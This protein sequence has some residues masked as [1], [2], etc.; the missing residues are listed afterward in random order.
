MVLQL[1]SEGKD[2]NF[3]C[4]MQLAVDVQIPDEFGGLNGEAIYI[5][6]AILPCLIYFHSFIR[7]FV[8]SF[9]RSF[10]QSGSQEVSQLV[11]FLFYI[12]A[13]FKCK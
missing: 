12:H 13:V 7:S 4:S 10:T 1:L 2:V 5:G 11:S 3:F 8:R 9:V 6:I